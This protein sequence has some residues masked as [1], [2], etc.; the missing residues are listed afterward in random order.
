MKKTTL[1]LLL[2]GLM[3]GGCGSTASGTESSD[4]GGLEAEMDDRN[5]AVIPLITRIRKLP[6]MTVQGGVPVLVKANNSFGASSRLEPLYVL[7]GLAMG[8]S[9][10]QV[11]SVVQPVDVKSIKVL[12]GADASF[13][14]SRG[15][16][17]VI[18][19]TTKSG[20]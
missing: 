7:D 20:G 14:G 11:E 6:G 17:G 19:I 15:A 18:I 3:L 13:Y 1:I 9:F 12:K 8:N 10:R 4:Q 16:N 2:A 5:S